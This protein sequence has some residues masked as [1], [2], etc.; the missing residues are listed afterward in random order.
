MCQEP[1]FVLCHLKVR[2]VPLPGSLTTRIE[3]SSRLRLVLWSGRHS[4]V[5]VSLSK[6][7]PGWKPLPL[8]SG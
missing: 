3:G 2:V 5:R 8:R 7:S 4:C 6:R 1:F